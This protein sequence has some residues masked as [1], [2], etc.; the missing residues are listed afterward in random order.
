MIDLDELRKR[1]E[2]ATKGPWR[3]EQGTTLVWGKC[4]PDDKTTYGM[5]VPV[6]ETKPHQ[7]WGS[8]RGLSIDDAEASAHFIAAA[9]PSVVLELIER[10]EMAEAEVVR[11]RVTCRD[12]VNEGTQCCSEITRIRALLARAGEAL[13]PFYTVDGA[14]LLDWTNDDG[15]SACA[16]K[17]ERI[18]DWFGPADFRT[19]RTVATEIEKEIGNV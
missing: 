1:A 19:A 13:K 10:V 2:A 18:F 9:N 12:A 3:V 14:E 5:G 16:P 17:N 4:D 8:R 7:G 6:A 11:W 15:W